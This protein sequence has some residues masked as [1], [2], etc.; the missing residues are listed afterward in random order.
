MR[1][2]GVAIAAVLTI[3]A[4]AP[5]LTSQSPSVSSP[6]PTPN[7]GKPEGWP[8]RHPVPTIPDSGGPTSLPKPSLTEP[9]A[10][11]E[12][13]HDPNRV[14]DGVV[15]MLALLGVETAP[16]EA[17]DQNAP[18]ARLRLT[19]AEVRAL[20]EMGKADA[21]AQDANEPYRFASLLRAL[22]SS[23]PGVSADRLSEIFTQHYAGRPN[24]PVP[25]ILLGQPL[26]PDTPLLRPELWLLLAD[27]VLRPL[28]RAGQTPG[29]AWLV[30]SGFRSPDES[31][32]A[33]DVWA[34]LHVRLPLI[35]EA[36]IAVTS[37]ARGH[38]GHGGPG[39]PVS[40]EARLSA[41]PVRLQSTPSPLTPRSASLAG[42]TATWNVDDAIRAHAAAAPSS[43]TTIG[44]DGVA[45]FSLTP[46]AEGANGRGRVRSETGV[47]SVLIGLT[48]FASKV[49]GVPIESWDESKAESVAVATGVA[50]DWHVAG[51]E[52]STRS[53]QAA[54]SDSLEFTVTNVYDVGSA[55]GAF[56]LT[57]QGVDTASGTLTL[58]EDGIYRG[59]AN[60]AVLSRIRLPGKTCAPYG[61]GWQRA[62]VVAVPL[63]RNQVPGQQTAAFYTAVHR[64]G[65][66]SWLR[67]RESIYLRLEFI[68]KTAP[69][70]DPRDGCQ[71]E[72]PGPRSAATPNFIPLNDAQWTIEGFGSVGGQDTVN[73]A[74]YAIA[75][76]EAG[77]LRY[78]DHTSDNSAN[79]S[80]NVGSIDLGRLLKANSTWYVSVSRTKSN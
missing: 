57:R 41:K 52:Q 18:R 65:D 13:L 25:Q 9:F 48:D 16:D 69:A 36:S 14:A 35:R 60:L 31:R 47:V 55:V 61:F 71:D 45:R 32:W 6:A 7:F 15:S 46:K 54:R 49:Y 8:E 64:P 78:E 23:M 29:T 39:A 73:R 20:I 40:L 27:A 53:G 75:A 56:A 5:G 68:P 43:R 21:E 58:D 67:G 44:G 4:V 17:G 34:E 51:G 19:P 22:S 77:L 2:V 1:T 12:A 11:G 38:E 59:T 66:Y 37:G 28:A 26:E 10:I 24:D 62:D 3:L 80:L 30:T 79:S 42:L 33:R 50:M 74:G 63:A 70:Y 72:I 76:P